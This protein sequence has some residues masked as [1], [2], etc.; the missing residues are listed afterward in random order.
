MIDLEYKEEVAT[1]TFRGVTERVVIGCN[2]KTEQWVMHYLLP[3]QDGDSPQAM[4][5]DGES[6][7]DILR[8]TKRF[9]IGH[10]RALVENV[11]QA[12]EQGRR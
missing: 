11:I 10:G 3:G 4:I 12:W 7:E 5:T 1:F 2:P 6:R 8:R 9:M